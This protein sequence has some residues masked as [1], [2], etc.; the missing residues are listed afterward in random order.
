MKDSRVY[1]AID[2]YGQTFHGLRNPRKELLNR[3]CRKHA[4][5]MFIDVNGE[6][7][8]VG[9]IIGE[10]WLTLYEVLPYER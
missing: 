7:K 5:K 1:M 6:A 4:D 8:H 10:L 2:Q 3:L 9:Y